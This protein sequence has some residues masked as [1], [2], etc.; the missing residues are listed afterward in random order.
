MIMRRLF[1]S[2]IIISLTLIFSCQHKPATQFDVI[3]S[4]ETGIKFNNTIN[5]NEYFNILTFEYFYNGGGVGIG[6]FNNDGLSDI[7]FSGNVVNNRLYLNKGDLQFTDISG[8]A[9]IQASDKWCTGVAVVDI[10]LDGWLDIYVCTSVYNPDKRGNILF[11][12][13]GLDESGIPVFKDSAEAYGIADAGFSIQGVFFDYDNDNDLDLYVLTNQVETISP[14][15]HRVKINNGSSPS[16]DRLYRNNGDGT[17]TNTTQEAGIFY[18]GY[19]LGISVQDFNQDGWKDLYITNDYMTNDVM[20]INNKDGSFTNQIKHY[21]KHQNHSAMGHDVADINNDGLV[22]IFALDMVPEDVQNMK[23]TMLPTKYNDYVMNTNFGYEHQ[24][25]RNVLQINNGSD[26]FGNHTFSEISLYSG[27]F[28]TYWSWAPLFADFDNDG[29][30]DL[31]ISNGF[32]KDVTDMDFGAVRYQRSMAFEKEELL[33]T[34]PESRVPNFLYRNVDGISFEKKTKEWGLGDPSFSNGAVFSDLD[35]DGDL[36]II[37]NNINQEAYIYR[38]NQREFHP[39]EGNYLRIDLNGPSLNPLGIGSR[40]TVWTEGERQYF[41]FSPYR[42]YISSVEPYIHIGLGDYTYVDSIEVV[43]P[44]NTKK[45]IG[46]TSANQIIHV[47]YE[48]SIDKHREDRPVKPRFFTEASDSFQLKFKHFDDVFIDFNIQLTIPH[49]FSQYGPSISVGDIN[50]DSKMDFFLGGSLGSAGT[51]F[52][53]QGGTFIQQYFDQDYQKNQEDL[54]T[55]LFDADQDGDLDLYIVSGSYEQALSERAYTDRLY[56]N[57]G[58]G[59]FKKLEA[60]LPEFLVS[61]SC[62]KASDYDQDGDLDL[63]IGGRLQ[64]GKYPLPTSSFL[65][66]NISEEGQ[67]QFR[68]ATAEDCPD[69]TDLGLVLDALWT[70]F[71]N[72]HQADLV[73]V[74]EWMPITFFENQNGKLV[75]ITDQTGISQYTGLWK[76]LAGADFDNDG[77]IDY[78]AGNLGE[79]SLY[80]ASLAEPVIAYADDYDNNGMTDIIIG[81]YFTDINGKRDLYPVHSADDLLKQVPVFKDR[82]KTY[83]DYGNTRLDDVFTETERSNSYKISATCLSTSYLENLGNGA[84]RLIRLPNKVQFA[85]VYG[86]VALDI[87]EDN[88]TDIILVGNDYGNNPYWGRYDAFNGLVLLNEGDNEWKEMM[89]PE[90]GFFVPG[91]GKSLAIFPISTEESLMLAAQNQDS[92]KVFKRKHSSNAVNISAATASAIIYSDGSKKKVEFYYGHSFLSQS[93][94]TL[95]LREETDSVAFFDYSGKRLK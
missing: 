4:S 82:F 94:R 35:N 91:D 19:G 87:N 23:S 31:F 63:F 68:D 80:K 47:N 69:L 84:F 76:S 45:V 12:N 38:N 39:A 25:I 72:D 93:A 57:D 16:N 8:E 6:D 36:D 34:I 61:G 74:G 51:F 53:Q 95:Y 18:E 67:I 75:N 37:T 89:Y 85:P 9:G 22:D 59:N 29:L 79:N 13:Q 65:L 27:V 92:L 7:F 32:P 48:N 66:E 90:S 21:I 71:N 58:S 2:F 83:A 54:G 3:P 42:G 10:N 41:E 14:N 70:D 77:D 30:K 50:G 28:A 55:L 20:L 11:I 81:R 17:F 73:V 86:M 52:I 62:V 56:E 33:E 1:L 26:Y 44:D 78:V 40:I 43:W 24:Y 64:P 49:Q 15:R 88:L 5:E 46:T 60:A